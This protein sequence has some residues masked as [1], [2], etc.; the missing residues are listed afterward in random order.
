MYQIYIR[1]KVICITFMLAYE[2]VYIFLN[3]GAFS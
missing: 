1:L 3:K 2:N